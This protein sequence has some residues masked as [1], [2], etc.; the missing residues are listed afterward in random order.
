MGEKSRRLE[1]VRKVENNFRNFYESKKY[2]DVTLI[3]EGKKYPVHRIILSTFSETFDKIFS[4]GMKESTEKE[5]ILGDIKS[6]TLEVLLKFI[7]LHDGIE[8]NESN[9]IDVLCASVFYGI[10]ELRVISEE[11]VISYL[12]FD[13]L[14]DLFSVS[15]ATNS[16]ELQR[17]CSNMFAV[18]F[19]KLSTFKDALLLDFQN[20]IE[21]FCDLKLRTSE[22]IVLEFAMKWYNE[23]KDEESSFKIF[24]YIDYLEV[25][26]KS[27]VKF[28]I[29]FKDE[30]KYNPSLKPLFTNPKVCRSPDCALTIM[31]YFKESTNGI[32]S[33]LVD[34]IAKPVYCDMNFE[35]GGWMLV[36]RHKPSQKWD[37]PKDKLKG[38]A[39][40]GNIDFNKVSPTINE[41][42]SLKFD[43]IP[44]TYFL[45]ITGDGKKWLICHKDSVYQHWG[46]I[47]GTR[48]EKSH[49]F[50][51]PYSRN[52]CKRIGVQ[53][54]P[55]I[56]ARD[57]LTNGYHSGID[58]DY[59]SMLYGEYWN[60]SGWTFYLNN[61]NGC[62]VFIK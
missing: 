2:S 60:R 29:N 48:I 54:D 58:D 44:F 13:N 34:G 61:N 1:K 8:L 31:K 5:I 23:H 56:S 6:S 11:S 10:E 45:F 38:N 12:D 62:N 57:H 41:S 24:H 42:F 39:Q 30:M 19:E 28:E 27:L 21:I 32:Y 17:K 33:I 52:W 51:Q 14:F 22:D 43:T 50:D 59:H 26:K 49:L 53:E 16:K 15:I 3:C 37:N 20:I 18:H 47:V 46:G 35:G 40:Y 25:S 36:R 9:T 7:Y 55:W 4:N